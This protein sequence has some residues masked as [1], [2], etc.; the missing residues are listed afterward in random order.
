MSEFDNTKI[1]EFGDVEKDYKTQ[2]LGHSFDP[3]RYI[4]DGVKVGND[5]DV[6][7]DEYC[8]GY[9]PYSAI[10]KLEVYQTCG[11]K[12]IKYAMTEVS[13]N[14]YGFWKILE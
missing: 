13:N 9:D 3:P 8:Y 4:I 11:E 14:V 7:L 6:R 10:Q 1:D 12:T 2:Y 5:D